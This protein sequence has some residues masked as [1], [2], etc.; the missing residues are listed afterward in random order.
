MKLKHPLIF[1][2]LF[3]TILFSILLYNPLVS[4]SQANIT[5]L[6]RIFGNTIGAFVLYAP[7]NNQYTYYNEERCNQNFPPL[8][9][10]KIPNSIISLETGAIADETITVSYDSQKYPSED[11]WPPHWK[12]ENNLRSALK[13]SVVWFYRE[14][15]LKVGDA[16]MKKYLAHFQY[17]NQD[18]SGGLDK[19]WL[20][21]SLK[22]SPK[23]QVE[24]LRKFYNDEFLVSKRTANIVKDILVLE[25]T[26][27][28]KLSAKTGT[29]FLEDDN[30]LGWLVGYLE[31]SD[32]VYFFALNLEGKQEEASGKKRLEMTKQI[33]TQL[34]IL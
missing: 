8:S 1:L 6:S 2:G 25:E 20:S 32:D 24:F 11:W 12:Q 28:Y 21:S 16:K 23:Q 7:Q 26:D 14:L 4:P 22:I 3:I 30:I 15:A 29:D 5:D 13:Y 18:I 27:T 31:K 33:F 17:G 19:F 34:G 10:F 9:T